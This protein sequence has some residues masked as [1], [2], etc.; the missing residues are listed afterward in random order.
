MKKYILAIDQ[1]TT[2]T[3][4]IFIDKN[5][6]ALFKAQRPVD[7][8]FPKP[9]W[10]EVDADRVW[11]SVIDVINELLVVS[12]ASMD[13][14]AAIGI[15]NQR[16]TAVVWDK[17]TGKAVHNGIVWQSKQTQQLCD[18]REDK[19]DFIQSRTGLRM[20]PYFSASKIRYILDHI[21]NGQA[22]AEAGELLFG[23]IDS[24]II[25]KLTKGKSHLTD[26]SNA[27]RTMLFN[28]FTMKYDPKLA[29]IWDIPLCMLPEV[30][31][32]TDFYGT[33]SFFAGEVPI[34]GVAGDQQAALFGQC[35][36]HKGESKNTYGT[37]CFMLMN[38]GDKPILSKAGLLTTVAWRENGVTTYALEGS[39][40]IGGAIVQWLRDQMR[41]FEDSADSEYYS[42]KV[43]DTAGTYFVPAFVGLGTPWWDDECRGAIFGL[44]RGADRHHL[45]RAGLES[46]AYQS[47]DVIEAMK[48]EA[49][50]EL[51]SLRVDGG[52]SGNA[53][54]MQFQADILQCEVAIPACLETTALG[55][56]Y[57][58]GLS[59]GFWKS[60]E[61]ILDKCRTVAR[62]YV[63]H[64]DPER[65]AELYD[66]WLCAVEAARAFKPKHGA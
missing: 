53:L 5:G 36:F 60:K 66:G 19:T 35:C 23:T 13:E 29:A 9:G 12:G 2:S 40:F 38:I 54:L 32:N 8:L 7:V 17:K 16:E 62:V 50:L 39:V 26:V 43:P 41:W 3:R 49:G 57:F 30:K 65:C 48:R 20:N 31:D 63:P 4:A 55:A 37:G 6:D 34:C 33:A 24:W 18:E 14:V 64:M 42:S 46:I 56:G 51:T 45:S 25:Y 61:E 58:A 22:R 10:V 21:E 52:A 15:T 44:T 11:I 28:I 27:S 1:G 47:K 59:C